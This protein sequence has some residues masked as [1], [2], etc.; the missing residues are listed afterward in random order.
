MKKQ[1]KSYGKLRGNREKEGRRK[2]KG[3]E[4]KK[5]KGGNREL[6][7]EIWKPKTEE[8][9]GNQKKLRLRE[10]ESASSKAKKKKRRKK[11]RRGAVDK[12]RRNCGNIGVAQIVTASWSNNQQGGFHFFHSSG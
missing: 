9:I 4:T 1:R 6:A 3:A 12:T 10:K 11:E 7:A 8:K 2:T 5:K